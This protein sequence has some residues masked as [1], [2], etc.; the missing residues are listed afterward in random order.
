M[1]WLSELD[2]EATEP[3]Q[4]TALYALPFEGVGTPH[5]Q[6]LVSYIIQLA[7]AHLVQPGTI[8]R[9]LSE[10]ATRNARADGRSAKKP[11]M[12]REPSSLLGTGAY[13]RRAVEAIEELTKQSGV[14]AGTLLHLAPLVARNGT[15]FLSTSRRWC[16]ACLLERFDGK[17]G[18]APEPLLW[19]IACSSACA[20]HELALSTSC[21]QCGKSQRHLPALPKNLYCWCCK[22][23]LAAPASKSARATERGL[24]NAEQLGW[25]IENREL[26]ERTALHQN[27]IEAIYRL[28]GGSGLRGLLAF[29]LGLGLTK[30]VVRQWLFRSNRPRLDLLMHVSFQ[31][32]LPLKSLLVEPRSIGRLDAREAEGIR[33]RA[34]PSPPCVDRLRDAFERAVAEGG[35]MPSL[36]KIAQRVGTSVD[37]LRY[38]FPDLCH[39]VSKQAK[40]ARAAERA[41]MA[42]DA[43]NLIA[44][45]GANLASGGH[46]PSYSAI[47]RALP[48]PARLRLE[49]EPAMKAVRARVA[50]ASGIIQPAGSRGGSRQLRLDDS[51]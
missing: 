19:S 6:S 9:V 34:A 27:F 17:S 33:V 14:A 42:E 47:L 25:L 7:A 44:S 46:Y 4:R 2:A 21:S 29:E 15:G 49:G 20:V 12:T 39:A 5:A 38:Y 30:S 16:P 22:S 31:S 3:P 11:L 13:A 50:V 51:W 23:P 26:L 18:A 40:A 37:S 8:L 28:W 41:R 35:K 10:H 43:P 48:R 24:W 36:R 1:Q 45:I 32:H